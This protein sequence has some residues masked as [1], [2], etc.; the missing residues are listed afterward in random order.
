MVRRTIQKP[1]GH[2]VKRPWSE[3]RRRWFLIAFAASVW[4]FFTNGLASL[5]RTFADGGIGPDAYHA[6]SV[7]GTFTIWTLL[8]AIPQ[9]R[10][11][12]FC[13]AVTLGLLVNAGIHESGLR[14]LAALGVWEAACEAGEGTAC[15]NAAE[16]YDDGRALFGGA[17]DASYLHR[18]AC[19]LGG[20]QTGSSCVI[21]RE[22]GLPANV[23]R[24]PATQCV[25]GARSQCLEIARSY[26]VAGQ[27]AAAYEWYARACQ[28]TTFHETLDAC[29]I[30]VNSGYPNHRLAACEKIDD[31]CAFDRS[32][33][34]L[35]LARR[36][37]RA[38]SPSA[39][40]D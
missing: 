40:V 1:S 17:T 36:C 4:L 21:A 32:H 18:R 12:Q 19:R 24:D 28:Q 30:L 13:L 11:G 25:Y 35:T 38:R 22:L 9:V 10:L 5:G 31:R 23:K 7:V 37:D 34:C 26:D 20:P 3:R 8:A 14:D 2:A 33:Q 27:Y 15:H 6:A 16:F 29:E 39:G